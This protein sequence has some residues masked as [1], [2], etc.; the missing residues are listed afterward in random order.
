MRP[1]NT[2]FRWATYILAG[3]AAGLAIGVVALF[4]AATLYGEALGFSA[5]A[6]AIFGCLITLLLSEPVGVAGMIVGAAVGGVAG[7][8]VFHAHHAKRN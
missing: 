4:V 3:G 5:G 1:M 6:C 2:A 8:V 7:A